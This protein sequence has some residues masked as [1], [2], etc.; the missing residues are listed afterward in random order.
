MNTRRCVNLFQATLIKMIRASHGKALDRIRSHSQSCGKRG[1][2]TARF[3]QDSAKCAEP[4][5]PS[6]S[7]SSK[8][9][10]SSAEEQC[11]LDTNSIGF[12]M[13]TL[14]IEKD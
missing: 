9:S 11:N 5:A 2:V 14:L 6:A 1:A 13:V 3:A 8:R 4:C 7:C 10:D 12:E